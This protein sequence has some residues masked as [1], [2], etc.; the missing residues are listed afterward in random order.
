MFQKICRYLGCKIHFLANE[1]NKQKFINFL[2]EK[3]QSQ[4]VQT[5]H[6]KGDADLLIALTGVKKAK[7][8]VTHVIGEDTDILV[9]LC[10]HADVDIFDL[11]FRSDKAVKPDTNVKSGTSK[12]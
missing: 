8:C 5:L 6:S 1:K 7:C 11:I 10:H 12:L 9:L 2:S 3:L 4:G